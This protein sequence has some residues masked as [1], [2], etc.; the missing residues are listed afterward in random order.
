MA[1]PMKIRARVDGDVVQ[2]RVLIGHVMETG[3]RKDAEGKLI[4]AHY[5]QLIDVTYDG[6][7]ILSAQ[8]GPA[9]SRNPYLA[10]KFRGGARG[11][12]IRVAWIDSTGQTGSGETAVE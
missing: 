5:I 2:V 7:S 12:K 10:F 11:G 3:L 9:V 4:P 8:W 6:R 1:N